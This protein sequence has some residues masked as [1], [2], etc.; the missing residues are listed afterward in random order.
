MKKNLLFL[1]SLGVTTLLYSWVGSN[2][3][4]KISYPAYNQ[5]QEITAPITFK[6]EVYNEEQGID[7]YVIEYWHDANNNWAADA[8]D[9]SSWI[10]LERVDNLSVYRDNNISKY[11]KG[12]KTIFQQNNQYLV[13]VYAVDLNGDVS[14]DTTVQYLTDVGDGSTWQ[15]EYVSAFKIKAGVTPPRPG[16]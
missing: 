16:R 10:V 1:F 3:Q 7:Y 2:M 6:G 15:N 12:T 13:R 14:A 4:V 11:E 9:T 8:G 5:R